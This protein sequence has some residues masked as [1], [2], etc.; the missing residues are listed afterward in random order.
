[1]NITEHC[2]GHLGCEFPATTAT[3][4]EVDGIAYDVIYRCDLHTV[5]IVAPPADLPA[6]LWNRFMGRE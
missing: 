6:Y 5:E 2:C 3:W 1:M 4:S